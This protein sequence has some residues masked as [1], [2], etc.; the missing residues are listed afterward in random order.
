MGGLLNT[1]TNKLMVVSRYVNLGIRISSRPMDD[2]IGEHCGFSAPRTRL[3]RRFATTE[4]NLLSPASS[5]I[6]KTYSGA[7]T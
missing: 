7:L 4:A 5:V 3:S 6:K 2:S 1:E